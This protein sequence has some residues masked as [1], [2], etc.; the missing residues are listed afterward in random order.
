MK[1]LHLISSGGLYGAEAVILSLMGALNATQ[2]HSCDLAVFH[3]PAQPQPALYD[4]A[5]RA[6]F[7]PRQVHL[8]KCKGQLDTEVGDRLRRLVQQGDTD[9]LHT[10]GY[11]A[12][13]YA[14]FA[15]KRD[16]PALVSTCHTW[17]DNDL[18]VRVYGALDRWVLR[19]FDGVA[20]VSAEVR[21]RLLAAGV[22]PASVR[23]IRNGVTMAPFLAA[24]RA[25]L[26]PTQSPGDL[27]RVGL[28]GRLAPEKGIDLFLRAIALL[29][30]RPPLARFEI[31]GEGPER[32]RLQ[33][34][35]AELHLA[36]TVTLAGSL[37][38]M[39]AFYTR[40]DLLV[41]ASRQE[42]LPVALLEGMASGLPVAATGV[43]AIPE[44]IENGITGL[45][46]PP[47]SPEALSQAIGSLLSDASLRHRL[48]AAGQRNVA[49][50]F[51]AER[52]AEDYM[53]FYKQALSV[54]NLAKDG[55]GRP[56][57]TDA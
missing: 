35:I 34:L 11:K 2:E 1:I 44:L 36:D 7:P 29:R 13:C 40:L 10:H 56:G 12:D 22:Q 24:E 15:W 45:L 33:A 49:E 26:A 42:G 25:R 3:N 17:Y 47:E 38:D 39:P 4:A 31:A 55:L 16:R 48:G 53:E 20:A 52:M 9:L 41:S 32:S 18:A 54:R 43:G 14:R 23:L 46:V 30:P 27:L 8:L 5:L 57:G 50:K 37:S 21:D 6:G 51:S 28:V 19:Q